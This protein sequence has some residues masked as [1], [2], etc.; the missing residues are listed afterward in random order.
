MQTL[1]I[2]PRVKPV[3]GTTV[4]DRSHP[5]GA[6]IIEFSTF[7]PIVS[8]LYGRA[9][10]VVGTSAIAPPLS[11]LGGSGLDMQSDPTRWAFEAKARHN[12]TSN[13][14]SVMCIFSSDSTWLSNKGL[15]GIWGASE[16]KWVLWSAT[17]SDFLGFIVRQGAVNKV[18]NA[19]ADSA[20]YAGGLVGVLG[21]YDG[22]NVIVYT[23]KYG[24]TDGGVKKVVGDANTSNLVSSTNRLTMGNYADDTDTV[25]RTGGRYYFLYSNRAY[26]PV[27]ATSLLNEPY[28]FLIPKV[29]NMYS[30]PAV[31]GA[32]TELFEIPHY[33]RGGF[34]PMHG[35]FSA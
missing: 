6:S 18:A 19:A 13:Q 33:M 26:N 31:A 35:G 16:L 8:G 17:T 21:V 27:E 5:I 2:D 30:V 22:A 23:K 1:E 34:N 29:R 3:P 20:F 12:L 28:Q 15:C 14:M 10:K 24:V 7:D 4:I 11:A 9:T 25:T 32:G